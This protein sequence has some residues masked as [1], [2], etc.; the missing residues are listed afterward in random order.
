MLSDQ[1][2]SVDGAEVRHLLAKDDIIKKH[3]SAYHP[4]GNV[5]AERGIRAVKKIISCLIAEHDLDDT[6]W[7]TLLSRVSYTLN[8]VPNTCTGFTPYRIM[9][10]GTRNPH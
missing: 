2:P 3:S 8:A 1:G 10:G 7:P 4:E 9:H 6:D 5:Q